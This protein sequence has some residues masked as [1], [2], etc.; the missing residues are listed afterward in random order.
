MQ[1]IKSILDAFSPSCGNIC[2]TDY[3]K[4]ADQATIQGAM[5]TIYDAGTNVTANYAALDSNAKVLCAPLA[6]LSSDCNACI[7]QIAEP[8][9]EA[10]QSIISDCTASN[11]GMVANVVLGY[12][13][14]PKPAAQP[15]SQQINEA[16]FNVDIQIMK[17]AEDMTQECIILCGND[18]ESSPDFDAGLLENAAQALQGLGTN[19]GINLGI[20]VN[21]FPYFCPPMA[22]FGAQ[23]KSCINSLPDGI[24]GTIS[25]IIAA[26][27]SGNS[28]A[29]IEF[30][31]GY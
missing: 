2:A 21:D 24:S 22:N 5:T 16:L 7:G 8:A 15:A 25:G 14:N 11:Y 28:E 20:E 19:D 31:M 1:N 6:F 26:C 12:D 30:V 13:P 4:H 18:Y 17:M 9:V 10:V 23:C 3:E 29:G 27:R